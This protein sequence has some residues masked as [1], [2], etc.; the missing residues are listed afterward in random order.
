MYTIFTKLVI[1]KIVYGF[2]FIIVAKKA[3]IVFLWFLKF[4][5]KKGKYLHLEHDHHYEHDFEHDFEHSYHDFEKHQHGPSYG[6]FFKKRDP[7]TP[8]KHSVYDADGS[9]SV[10]S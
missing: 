8:Q 4:L 7:Y 10:Q 2:L 9:Y 1:L 5:S 6:D 3:W